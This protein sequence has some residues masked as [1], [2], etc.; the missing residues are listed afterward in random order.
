MINAGGVRVAPI[1]I[2]EVL[3]AYPAVTGAACVEMP[4]SADT[5]VIA[6]FY[7][8]RNALEVSALETYVATK[9]ARYK[10]PRIYQRLKTL[11]LGANG[12]LLRRKLRD[13]WKGHLWTR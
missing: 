4:I 1:E 7:T 2:E 11:P 12:K 9:L 6:A 3:N 13:E 8:S 10:H 5:S